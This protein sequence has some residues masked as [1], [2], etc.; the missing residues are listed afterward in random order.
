MCNRG[1]CVRM[2]N[3]L[4]RGLDLRSRDESELVQQGRRKFVGAARWA[5]REAMLV[6]P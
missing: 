2:S 6:E 5:G 4:D 3:F 1:A